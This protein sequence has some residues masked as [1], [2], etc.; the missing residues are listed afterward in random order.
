MDET[1]GWYRASDGNWYYGRHPQPY[2]AP[3]APDGR[4]GWTAPVPVA[5]P[6]APPA[7]DGWVRR[8]KKL[9]TAGAAFAALVVVGALADSGTDTR[10]VRTVSEDTRPVAT[11]PAITPTT[12]PPTTPPPTTRPPETAAPT[13]APAPP[14][15]TV[16][17]S[18]T[19]TRRTTA[20]PARAA[21]KTCGAPAN[22]W[23]Y[24]FCGSGSFIASPPAS[25]CDYFDCIASFWE[26]TNGYVMQCEDGMFSH[27]GGQRGSCSHHGGNY[28]PLY[29]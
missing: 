15:R 8:H 4:G 28:R 24:H 20:P 13:T 22:P 5:P 27:S 25:F 14:P 6:P 29:R 11:T 26:R 23:G 9:S 12:V 19:A 17:P 1:Q 7:V 16:A 21:A 18:P 10:G 2:S 3:P